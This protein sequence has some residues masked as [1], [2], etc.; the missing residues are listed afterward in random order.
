VGCRGAAEGGVRRLRGREEIERRRDSQAQEGH[1]RAG[2]GAEGEDGGD[3][4]AEGVRQE[5]GRPWWG[6]SMIRAS[7]TYGASSICTSSTRIKFS[8]W[9]ST[10]SGR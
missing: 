3:G 4:G 6:P 1:R 8:I 7:M 5:A 2:E 10:G 9:Y